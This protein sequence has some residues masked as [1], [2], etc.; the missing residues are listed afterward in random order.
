MILLYYFYI[1][2][3]TMQHSYYRLHLTNLL[4]IFDQG[5]PDLRLKKPEANTVSLLIIPSP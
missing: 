1:T 4:K 5:L 2:R 3:F